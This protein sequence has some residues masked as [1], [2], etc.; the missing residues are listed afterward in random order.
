[1]DVVYFHYQKNN[2]CPVLEYFEQYV[3]LPG[4]SDRQADRKDEILAKIKARINW[5]RGNG[6]NLSPPHAK[7]LRR[8]KHCELC[9]KK[10]EN[11]VIRINYD[12][13]DG[14]IYLINA[15]EKPAKKTNESKTRKII[16]KANEEAD[17]YR[18]QIISDPSNYISYE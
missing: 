13:L 1:M 2:R 7:P 9:I 6:G 11:T 14:R 15:Y 8:W 5:L 17:Y 3:V 4:E 16:D 12:R 18:R 10:D